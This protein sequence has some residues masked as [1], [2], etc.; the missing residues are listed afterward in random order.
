MKC[1]SRCVSSFGISVRA[2]ILSVLIIFLCGGHLLAVTNLVLYYDF[3]T[4]EG[5]NVTDQSASGNDGVAVNDAD[6]VS[7]GVGGGAYA[8]D[9]A[10]DYIAIPDSNSLDIQ[11]SELTISAWVKPNAIGGYPYRPIVSKW[12]D[13]S[14]GNKRTWFFCLRGNDTNALG[15]NWSS[16]GVTWRKLIGVGEIQSNVWQHVVVS[17]K[18][19]NTSFYIDGQLDSYTWVLEDENRFQLRPEV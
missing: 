15:S 19:G 8:F 3:N 6:W 12:A 11:G 2:L 18:N 17:T 9:G 7:E 5:T 13:D 4:D 1:F 10:G 16:D 14:L